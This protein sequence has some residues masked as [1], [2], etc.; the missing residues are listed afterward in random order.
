MRQEVQDPATDRTQSQLCQ[1]EHQSVVKDV[2]K[3][4]AKIHKKQP[5]L[6]FDL[7]IHQRLRFWIDLN[8]LI[9]CDSIH[10]VFH[11]AQGSCHAVL[12]VLLLKR[13]LVG[14]L[15]VLPWLITGS[16]LL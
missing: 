5:D 4:R 8:A 1:F 3:G 11:E 15:K 10:A 12:Q 7:S 2:F 14:S 16:D 6:D 9:H 13:I